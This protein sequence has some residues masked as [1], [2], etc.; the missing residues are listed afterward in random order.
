MKL[1]FIGAFISA[2]AILVALGGLAWSVYSA[3]SSSASESLG[4]HGVLDSQRQS[5]SDKFYGDPI[6][7]SVGQSDN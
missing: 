6:V 2:M 3:P 1:G 5:I 4:L 7:Q